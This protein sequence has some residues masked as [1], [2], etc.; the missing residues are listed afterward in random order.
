M[1]NNNPNNNSVQ[2]VPIGKKVT[3][4]FNT[5]NKN[6]KQLYNAI[7]LGKLNT[8][9]RQ[10]ANGDNFSKA[11]VKSIINSTNRKFTPARI[12]IEREKLRLRNKLNAT[13]K[14]LN[15]L[16]LTT[17]NEIEK[18][19]N[20]NNNQKL[21]E[22]KKRL[23]SKLEKYEKQLLRRMGLLTR[24]IDARKDANRLS[25]LRKETNVEKY[26]RKTKNNK[27][28]NSVK[29]YTQKVENSKTSID[30]LKN[31]LYELF[32]K[33]SELKS[34]QLYDI[35]TG[36]IIKILGQ[37]LLILH[38]TLKGLKIE[39]NI[40]ENTKKRIY[41]FYSN[42]GITYQTYKPL[43][44]PK[45]ME[46]NDNMILNFISE[47]IILY[48]QLMLI[49]MRVKE[50]YGNIPSLEVIINSRTK[51]KYKNYYKELGLNKNN[52]KDE[53]KK[54]IINVSEMKK[55][56][57]NNVIRK[58]FSK[59]IT[60]VSFSKKAVSQASKFLDALIH[61]FSIYK[62]KENK[63]SKAIAKNN[64]PNNN[65]YVTNSRK[66]N[67]LKFNK[68]SIEAKRNFLAKEL[69]S[70]N[71]FNIKNHKNIT[72]NKKIL[73]FL[74]WLDMKHDF[75]TKIISK[76][77]NKFTGLD[78]IFGKTDMNIILN[79]PFVQDIINEDIARLGIGNIITAP[80]GFDQNL[81]ERFL[82][83]KINSKH[84]FRISTNAN[85]NSNI[86][87]I[88][89]KDKGNYLI[90]IDSSKTN[91]INTNRNSIKLI[92]LQGFVD[93][94]SSM[95]QTGK[96]FNYVKSAPRNNLK[97]LFKFNFVPRK[98]NLG[99]NL[100][101][102][103]VTENYKRKLKIKGNNYPVGLTKG[104]AIKSDNFKNKISK[105]FG[106]LMQIFSIASID[107]KHN[108][109]F[110]TIDNMASLIYY[111]VRKH[112]YG[113]DDKDIN[114]IFQTTNSV[115]IYGINDSKKI[116]NLLRKPFPQNNRKSNTN[117]SSVKSNNSNILSTNSN[118]PSPKRFKNL[119]TNNF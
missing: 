111:Y 2:S 66:E 97:K 91:G 3:T 42:Y 115:F 105:T 26:N 22:Y 107:P 35:R 114:L 7:T 69:I 65:G 56:I 106:D 24:N 41:K 83:K 112:I 110:K 99:N 53:I 29:K 75:G 47:F 11:Y 60:N 62:T 61:I 31:I 108:V 52:I 78:H 102:E 58:T 19:K 51:Y 1:S 73:K 77:F 54:T 63:I 80:T 117:T 45:T 103:Y 70:I 85:I 101:F 57:S 94:G 74:L 27:I 79:N 88:I 84:F 100:S 21:N 23:L 67:S 20:I 55:M 64:L 33:T 119:Q 36:K 104:E 18:I 14:I 81:Q 10:L 44:E 59:K 92:T 6:Y 72:L 28:Q 5:Y 68:A 90:S 113:C 43:E 95:T 13:P 89:S 8:G 93:P 34:N 37:K 4:H 39:K 32:P 40:N 118:E 15:H 76:T 46:E 17:K 16:N 109:Y 71:N 48:L 25:V 86:K 12:E 49:V 9:V 96:L 30:E 38:N 98:I 82:T 116:S 87:Q 50:Y